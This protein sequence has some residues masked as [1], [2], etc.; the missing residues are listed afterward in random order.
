MRCLLKFNT[1]PASSHL[2]GTDSYLITISPFPTRQGRTV[3]A[4]DWIEQVTELLV[5]SGTTAD[6]CR[7]S[8]RARTRKLSPLLPLSLT[9]LFF[10]HR[11]K[12]FRSFLRSYRL[13]RGSARIEEGCGWN[14]FSLARARR[15]G[16]R[17]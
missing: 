13:I 12:D 8:A 10:H 3:E 1:T 9:I 11:A 6:C 16:S 17:F 14:G 15:C 5:W 7:A 4:G 2:S